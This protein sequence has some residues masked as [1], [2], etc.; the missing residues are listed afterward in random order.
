ML[1]LVYLREDSSPSTL[2]TLFSPLLSKC[3]STCSMSRVCMSKGRPTPCILDV[4]LQ[5]D[6]VLCSV[7]AGTPKCEV[8]RCD[9]IIVLILPRTS[10]G[11]T[12]PTCLFGLHTVQYTTVRSRN[13]EFRFLGSSFARKVIKHF[14]YWNLFR[15]PASQS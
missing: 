15:Y 3:R 5:Y 13:S 11:D 10:T 6:D 9:A 14:L 7:N 1:S 12:L 4:Q 8:E 2:R